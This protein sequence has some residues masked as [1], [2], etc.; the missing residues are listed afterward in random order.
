[1]SEDLEAR[2]RAA[3]AARDARRAEREQLAH[4]TELARRVADVEREAANEKAIGEAERKHGAIGDK[5][6][7]VFTRLGVIIVGRPHTA[8]FKR[9][10]DTENAKLEDIEKLVLPSVLYPDRETVDRWLSEQ[11]GALGECAMKIS[12]LAGVNV[13]ALTGKS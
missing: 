6:D 2:L 13:A 1:M 9:F 5:I 12:R 7:T 8:L 4:D 10:Q 3:Q 11:P